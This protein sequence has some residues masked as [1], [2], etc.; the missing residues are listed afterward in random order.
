MTSTRTGTPTAVLIIFD[1]DR[2]DSNFEIY[3]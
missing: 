3:R 2:Q 1:S